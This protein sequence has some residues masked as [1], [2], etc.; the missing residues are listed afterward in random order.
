MVVTE[1]VVCSGY[2]PRVPV[3][4]QEIDPI[5]ILNQQFVHENGQ[6]SDLTVT[7]EIPNQ[8][9]FIVDK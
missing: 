6:L 2:H 1:T 7:L 3:D 4:W 8:V 9:E 5:R